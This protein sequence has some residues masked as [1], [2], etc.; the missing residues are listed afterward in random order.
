MRLS[1]LPVLA[2]LQR[3][4]CVGVVAL[5]VPLTLATGAVDTPTGSP[6]GGSPTPSEALPRLVIDAQGH[7]AIIR[8]LLF[9]ADGRERAGRRCDTADCTRKTRFSAF[10]C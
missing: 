6:H 10:P 7:T 9:T 5:L 4:A 1:I 2:L 3:R 8:R